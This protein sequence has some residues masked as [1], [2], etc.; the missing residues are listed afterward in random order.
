MNLYI[1]VDENNNPIGHPHFEDNM[2]ML[3]PYNDFNISVPDGWKKFTRVA[4][5]SIGPYQKFDDCG[6]ENC[7][8]WTHNGLTY[9]YDE[10]EDIVKDVW[11]VSDM[12]EAEI[13][14]K[15]RITK[16]DWATNGWASWSFNEETCKFEAPVPYP[17]DG[18][19][20]LWDEDTTSWV[21]L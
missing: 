8:A 17:N 11:H 20:Y 14:E 13:A 21:A 16:E 15:Q 18:G 10:A 7:D 4:P 1:K 5:P 6:A 2:M 3:Y 19:L 12:S 9:E